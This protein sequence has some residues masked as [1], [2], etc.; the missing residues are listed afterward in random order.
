M[1]HDI[2]ALVLENAAAHPERTA[3]R[4]AA[5]VT[6]GELSRRARGFATALAARKAQP[7]DTVLLAA[8]LMP[9]DAVA[10]ALGTLA[11]GCTLAV[12][13]PRLEPG[14][15]SRRMEAAEPAFAV[16]D[17]RLYRG[18]GPFGASRG[19]V[20]V[21]DFGKLPVQHF[22][23]G[24]RHLGTPFASVPLRKALNADPVGP[25][26]AD[27][28]GPSIIDVAADG[29]EVSH[30]R[31][32]LGAAAEALAKVAR[33]GGRSVLF[34]EHFTPGLAVLA[35]GGT[36]V[37]PSA[38][39]ERSGAPRW[40]AEAAHVHPTHVYLSPEAVGAVL[41]DLDQRRSRI[42]LRGWTQ[43][44]TRPEGAR[45]SLRTR[46]E[47]L[48]PGADLMAVH[49]IAEVLPVSADAA[50]EILYPHGDILSGVILGS[51]ARTSAT[52]QD[53]VLSGD[54]QRRG[55]VAPPAHPLSRGGTVFRPDPYEEAIGR[56]PGV[57]ACA[58]VG[59][60]GGPGG[61]D[62]VVLAVSPA[63]SAEPPG[64][65]RSRI[66]A[67]LLQVLD[68][69]AMPD[70]VVVLPVL[71]RRGGEIDRAGLAADAATLSEVAHAVAAASAGSAA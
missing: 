12:A 56:L 33:L 27:P 45:Y 55:N 2:V 35:A 47:Q 24:R 62:V 69:V 42:G 66:E 40:A 44:I 48:L 57:A 52:E 26:H 67:H 13:P 30:S 46:F 60:P 53:T 25:V 4:A 43:F 49:G 59:V 20:T 50:G 54:A 65:T 10:V 28:T 1:P 39:P 21:R 15:F 29:T 71:P 5:D 70:V 32:S 16:G 7:G 68:P 41:D 51:S 22:H 31:A 63:N 9:S 64:R 58:L 14:E 23:T 61:D 38:A 11:A 17:E 6:Y 36:W 37:V 19:G 8:D 18:S 34:T 3:L